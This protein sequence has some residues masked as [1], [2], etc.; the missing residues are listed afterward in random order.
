[1]MNYLKKIKKKDK[2][3]FELIKGGSLNFIFYGLNLFVVYFL[4][5]IITKFYGP[6]AYGR[7]SIIKSLILLL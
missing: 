5:I 3:L 6:S 1:M 4:A 2:D 7:Y